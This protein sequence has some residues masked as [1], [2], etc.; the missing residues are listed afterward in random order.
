M[1]NSIRWLNSWGSNGLATY[2]LLKKGI[3]RESVEQGLPGFV[4]KV[5][6]KDMWTHLQIFLQPL[7]E[8]HLHSGD[9]PYQA[10][11]HNFGSTSTV[12]IFSI[13]AVFILL[14][15]CINF[16][17]LATARSTKRLKEIGMRK[18]L[19][20]TRRNL[21]YQFLGESV[22]ISL[23]AFMLSLLLAEL[24]F[25]Y[26]KSI[27]E[28]R[29][30]FTY[31][32][33]LSFLL[34]L[35]GIAILVGIVAGSYPAFFLSRLQPA[36]S[37]KGLAISVTR[38][39]N[40]RKTL[41]VLQFSIA[42]ALIVCTEIVS[43]QMSYVA[44]MGLGFNRQQVLYI[45]LHSKNAVEKVGLL[46]TELLKNSDIMDVAAGSGLTGASGN[47]GTETVVGT[48]SQVQMDM[49]R[50]FIDYD[51]IK[52]MQ[53][54]IVQGRDFS[55]DI[56]SD[57]SAVIINE[58]AAHKFGWKNSIGKQ[59]EGTPVGTVIGVVKD[60][61][62]A[63][64]HD[65]IGPLIMRIDPQR[66]EYMLVRLE[67]GK[68]REAVDFIGATWKRIIPTEPFDYSFLDQ[69]V[70]EM[71]K[72]DIRTERIFNFFSSL[73]IFIACLGLF[74]LATYTAEQRTKE[75]GIRK[76]LG[77]SV[78]GIVVL[79]A[80]DFLWL[81]TIASLVAVPIAYFV[82]SR[83]LQEF[84]YRINIGVLVFVAAGIVAV[85]IAFITMSFQ[86]IKAATAN[87]I[88]SLHYE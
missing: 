50:S 12:Y 25:P 6:P 13:I 14:I 64:L 73:A 61:N 24:A 28:E 30:I 71:Y 44:S 86:A 51:Y 59:F 26:F 84:A 21:I 37:L 75:I 18:V 72:T 7:K 80:K 36:Q 17:N 43:G 16:M 47:D 38:R 57:S 45:P 60:F 81:V 52:T 66:V 39:A 2:V 31:R 78:K 8:I 74:G 20:S 22:I 49:T 48:N 54:Q 76:V 27:F 82:M 5:V 40:F 35:L 69:F 10:Y 65:K 63:S 62:F 29:I 56:A 58:T 23:L 32:D 83:W 33:S 41:V 68:P 77:A 15:G 53:M 87:P 85:T 70:D 67:P 4:D 3:T 19:G 1:E 11:N 79:L 46:K 42:I 88:E 34:E 55:R 9:I